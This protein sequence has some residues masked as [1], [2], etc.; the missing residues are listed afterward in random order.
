MFA[1]PAVGRFTGECIVGATRK[2]DVVV[3]LWD[4]RVMPIECKVS[5]SELNSIKRLTNDA[6]VKARA[7]I[8]DLGRNNVVPV[9]VLSGVFGLRHLS[10]AQ[11]R[12]LTLFLGAFAGRT[13]V[14]RRGDAGESPAT[15][16]RPARRCR[17]GRATGGDKAMVSI[18]EIQEAIRVL[19]ETEYARLRQWISDLDWE[20][21]DSQVEA[22]AEAG[23]LDS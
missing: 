23:R 8:D 2:A 9:A 10:E 5:N 15:S 7:W 13:A 1:A 21:W 17:I 4:G 18:T 14:V 19:P 6:L 20:R 22:D 12:G 3:R 16:P 11:D